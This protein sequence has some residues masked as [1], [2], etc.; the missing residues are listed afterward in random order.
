MLGFD[1]KK[2]VCSV[3]LCV[4][5]GGCQ[6]LSRQAGENGALVFTSTNQV[7][8]TCTIEKF[9]DARYSDFAAR[10]FQVRCGSWEH[11]SGYF[12]EVQPEQPADSLEQWSK[13]GAWIEQL[14]Q[15]LNCE[16]GR[17]EVILDKI[18]ALVLDCSLRN[19]DWPYI[20]LITEIDGTVFLADGI[21]AVFAI[22]EQGIGVVSGRLNVESIDETSS[23]SIAMANI[24][25]RLRNVY[26]GAGDIKQYYRLMATG[27]YYNSIKDFTTAAQRY[28]DALALR[29][30]IMGAHNPGVLDPL[31]HLALERSNQALFTEAD[32]LFDKAGV[33]AEQTLDQTDR[34]RY[35]SYLALHA[36]NQQ[37]FQE[38]Y[39]FAH[40]ASEIRRQVMAGQN[41]VGPSLGINRVD[42]RERAS[43][44]VIGEIDQPAGV[45]IVQSLY[46][47]AAMLER[48]GRLTDAE[49]VLRK[50]LAILENAEELPSSW[51]PEILGLKAR[52]ARS[53]GSVAEPSQY[54]EKAVKIWEEI[55][56]GER[57]SVIYYMKLGA[58]YKA[59]GLLEPAINS[60]NRAIDLVKSHSGSLSYDQLRPYFQTGLELAEKY[61]DRSAAIQARMFEAG[62]L[63][64]TEITS[65]TIAQA[66]ARLAAGKGPAAELVRDF[67]EAQDER[68]LLYRTYE[69]ELAKIDSETQRKRVEELE[70]RLAEIN[71]RIGDL[72]L[73]V[74][75]AL[76]RYNQLVD[77]VVDA[78]QVGDLLRP[79]EAL[80]QVL[81][82]S[83]EGLLFVV[84]EK[85]IQAVPL[86]LSLSESE[87]IVARLRSGLQPEAGGLAEFDVGLAHQ[88]FNRLFR[89]VADEIEVE[90]L[91]TIP[92]GALL[93]LPFGLL[94]T[95]KPEPVSG[96]D[97]RSISWLAKHTSISLLPSVQSFVGLRAI[98]RSAEA[99]KDFIG[100]ADF[101][102][103]S[104]DRLNGVT[105]KLPAACQSDPERLKFHRQQL[106][107]MGP[108]DITR[109]EVTEIAGL[110]SGNT[111]DLLFGE[112][113]TDNEIEH[114]PLNEYR[115]LYFATHGL[116]PSD[117]ECQS[118]PALVTSL[119]EKPGGTGDGLLD[120]DEIL[121][122][123]LNADLVV[124][125]ACNSGGSGSKTGGES[126]SGLARAFFFAG[127]R[128][129]IVSHWLAENNATVQLMVTLFRQTG[130]NPNQGLA[131][132]LRVAQLSLIERAEDPNLRALSHPLIWAAFTVVGDGAKGAAKN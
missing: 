9:F 38:A 64:R 129:L 2:I 119:P 18:N 76:P 111:S 91:I 56:P 10:Q 117:L 43:L 82:G 92:A 121:D 69:A 60:F 66:V 84:R 86:D 103:F 24:E 98:A 79:G 47:E 130:S 58:S 49:P 44:Q 95:E 41:S 30:K 31:M 55:A 20:S 67:Q 96:Y 104:A 14:E 48:L 101:E 90:H 50:A 128:S 85:K 45:D 110:F 25:K 59:Q 131:D 75:S 81:L 132:A 125:S 46:I 94:V 54:L 6:S 57:P 120:M 115:I 100:F 124:L 34:A 63:V 114:L 13:S 5:T 78:N 65:R 16:P 21:P 12:F 99:S 4:L 83:Q 93:S 11:P 107:A 53:K 88:L 3:L 36:A 118:V 42:G 27:Q 40:R 113:F 80:I 71:Q 87:E 1:T 28:L 102:A 70:Q 74:Q 37:N 77:S 68:N 109:D 123:R 127:A 116:L 22:L 32:A 29:E 72:S 105:F 35:L 108:L 33:F 73:Q 112:Q 62:Q 126:L 52:I 89:S 26:Y 39:E 8:E 15:K 7:G 106:M 61:P 122:L 19:G 23:R 17:A 51:K 97:Y